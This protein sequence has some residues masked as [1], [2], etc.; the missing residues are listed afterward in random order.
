MTAQLAGVHASSSAEDAS[1]VVHTHVLFCSSLNPQPLA[2]TTSQL[3][4]QLCLPMS[5]IRCEQRAFPHARSLANT[6]LLLLS[7]D[8][9]ASV[10]E[11]EPTTRASRLQGHLL[12]RLCWPHH[13]TPD[14]RRTPPPS[15]QLWRLVLQH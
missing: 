2:L 8:R 15:L 9:E 5:N 12:T 4:S 11:L 6:T 14:L 10:S 3:A 13:Q 7:D 1:P